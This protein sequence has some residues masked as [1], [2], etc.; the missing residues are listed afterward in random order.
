MTIDK[1]QGAI[2]NYQPATIK[3]SARGT[4]WKIEKRGNSSAIHFWICVWVVYRLFQ[5]T[6]KCHPVVC[7][8]LLPAAGKVP[9]CVRWRPGTC[10]MPPGHVQT[11]PGHFEIASCRLQQ[12]SLS[13]Q[14][15]AE[16]CTTLFSTD[17]YSYGLE[18]LLSCR[19]DKVNARIERA[20]VYCAIGSG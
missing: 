11:A 7:R 15:A 19:N 5:E 10:E 6:C 8:W 4:E 14:C 9:G 12:L 3:G 16:S 1:G 18:K 17:F 13:M 20:E 2:D